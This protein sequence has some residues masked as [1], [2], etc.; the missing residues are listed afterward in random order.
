[1]TDTTEASSDAYSSERQF[2]ENLLNQ[3]ANFALVVF[4]LALAGAA[5]LNDRVSQAVTLG[6]ST[7]LAALL[8]MATSRA[9]W[10]LDIMFADLADNHPARTTDRSTTAGHENYT[11]NRALAPCL[12]RPVVAKSRRRL[13]G[14]YIPW[15][16]VCMLSVATVLAGCGRLVRPDDEAYLLRREVQSLREEGAQSFRLAAD[17]LSRLELEL[18]AIRDTLAKVRPANM[19]AK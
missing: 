15:T 1:M 2:L 17:R 12:L 9:Q 6:A 4:G 10:K 19:A 5:T 16:I 18:Q 3:R 13:I 8:A 14:Y 11:R 7:L